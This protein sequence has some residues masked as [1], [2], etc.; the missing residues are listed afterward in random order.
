M[1]RPGITVVAASVVVA[2]AGCATESHL[3]I[4][5]AAAVGAVPSRSP[6]SATTLPHPTAS[7]PARPR[8]VMTMPHD[9]ALVS[10]DPSGNLGFHDQVSDGWQLVGA[11]EIDGSG[12]WVVVRADVG[13]VPGQVIGKVYRPNEAHDDVVTVRFAK[14]LA[15]GPLWVSLNID[16]GTAKRLEFPGPDRPVQFAGADLATRLV[17]TVR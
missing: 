5:A 17:L 7:S 2:L 13:G 8:D 16:A 6:A 11:A 4:P 9:L 12:G 1:I 3:D 10:S 14:R 15:S